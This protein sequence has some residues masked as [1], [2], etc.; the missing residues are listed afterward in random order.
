V[1]KPPSTPSTLAGTS[2]SPYVRA[3]IRHASSAPHALR[4]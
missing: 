4:V 3:D 1:P 2:C